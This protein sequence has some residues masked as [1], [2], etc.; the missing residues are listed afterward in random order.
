M[1]MRRSALDEVGLF[2][3]GYWMYM[4]DLDLCYR[5]ARRAGS[6]GTSP[7]VTVV[8][9]KAGTSGKY[10]S[11]RLNYAFHYG[12]LRF[13]RKHYARAR[14]PLV[15][16]AVYVGIGAQARLVAHHD[17]RWPRG[18]MERVSVL[19][20]CYADAHLVERSLPRLLEGTKSE[21]EVLLLNNDPTQSRAAAEPRRAAR[22]TR[23][24]DCSSWRH[25]A[26]FAR[27]IN[28]GIAATT[29]ELVFFANSDLFVADGYVDEMARFFERRPTRRLRH[30][31]GA[32]LRPRRRSRDGR[33]RHHR[34]RHPAQPARRRPRGERAGRRPVRARGGGLQRERRGAGRAHD[35]R[36][37]PSRARRVPG[38]GLRHVQG[39]RR[40]LLAPAP[41][42][43]G[44]LVRADARSRTTPARAAGSRTRTTSPLRARSTRTSAPSRAT[45]APTR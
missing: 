12:M 31:K 16:V 30:R 14:N 11:P 39:G 10:R 7:S 6:R 1:L 17:V 41:R 15:N 43:L 2:D 38:R 19:V 27:A 24:F 32:P 4:E 45:S 42:G 13:Y 22:E 44:V 9:T 35:E 26:G 18:R 40:P 37:S 20:P 21:L 23:G 33:H 25:G 29:G 5:M 3:E 28:E 36:S 8:H 34:A